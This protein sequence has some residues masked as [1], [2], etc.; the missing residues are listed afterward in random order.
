MSCCSSLKNS[1]VAPIILLLKR[2]WTREREER[3]EG[4]VLTIIRTFRTQVQS[5]ILV[6]SLSSAAN[7]DRS[8]DP[9]FAAEV[10]GLHVLNSSAEPVQ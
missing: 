8:I 5:K 1:H 3:G 7:V 4:W 9:Y 2:S 6:S 10:T